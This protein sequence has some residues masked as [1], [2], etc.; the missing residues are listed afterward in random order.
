MFKYA[1]G[2]P[3][4][5]ADTRQ[6][7]LDTALRLFEQRGYAGTTMRAIAAEAG[8]ATGNAY[9]WFA[10]KDELVQEL[11]QRIQ[12]DHRARAAVILAGGGTL[13][14]RLRAV[15]HAYLDVIEPHHGFGVAFLSTAIR[16]DSPANPLSDDSSGAREASMSIYRDVVAGARP[17]VTP[18]L[19]AVL[20]DL[21]WLCHLGVTLL[22]VSDA[23][24]G[25]QRTRRVVDTA[26]PLVTGLARLARLPMAAAFVDQLDRVLAAV[27][28]RPGTP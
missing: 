3:A 28:E 1:A 18:R 6:L 9:Y 15:E 25:Q 7:I 13:A 23:S 24:A 4:P 22:W 21:L 20:P 10:N 2:M 8:V 12:A 14:D 26:V 27:L 19:R 5:K 17:A 16:S 11:Y